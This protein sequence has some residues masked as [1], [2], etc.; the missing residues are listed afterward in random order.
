VTVKVLAGPVIPHGGARGRRD[1]RR[2]ARRA[3]P[4]LRRAWSWRMCGAA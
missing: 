1:G 2:S 3:G 4:R